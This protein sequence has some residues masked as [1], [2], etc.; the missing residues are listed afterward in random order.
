[1]LLA[2]GGGQSPVSL[3]HPGAA[4]F[5]KRFCLQDVF[6]Q[7]KYDPFFTIEMAPGMGDSGEEELL[8]LLD[9]GRPLHPSKIAIHLL[10]LLD[11]RIPLADLF[12]AMLERSE[13]E[14]IF[15]VRMSF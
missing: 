6:R 7:R 5:G 14:L 15:R 1:M 9:P 13:K 11:K 3:I 8:S 4:Q 12:K 10:V 2:D